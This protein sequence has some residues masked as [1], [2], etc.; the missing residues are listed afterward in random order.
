MTRR[1]HS[2]CIPCSGVGVGVGT[3][4]GVFVNGGVKLGPRILG[5]A[6]LGANEEKL[7]GRENIGADGPGVVVGAIVVVATLLGGVN[8]DCAVAG[9]VGGGANIEDA[10]FSPGVEN[11]DEIGGVLGRV[12]S[13]VGCAGR[14]GVH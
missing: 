12:E 4:D 10:D 14:G 1:T 2:A 9:V 3:G 6:V 7:V 11:N 5:I 8:T 13:S